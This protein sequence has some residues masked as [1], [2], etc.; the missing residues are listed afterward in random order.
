[1]QLPIILAKTKKIFCLFLC[2]CW[3]DR[4]HFP[5][6][7]K[8]EILLTSWVGQIGRDFDAIIPAFLRKKFILLLYYSRTSSEFESMQHI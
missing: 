4:I 5:P 3:R 1:M 7:R 6:K 2:I 8:D